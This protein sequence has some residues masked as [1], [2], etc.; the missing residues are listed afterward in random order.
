MCVIVVYK[1][2]YVSAAVRVRIREREMGIHDTNHWDGPAYP[3]YSTYGARIQSYSNWP[4]TVKQKPQ[5]LSEAGFF[6][7]GKPL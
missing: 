1:F 3:G 7:E 6:Y 4:S 5:Q 2:K